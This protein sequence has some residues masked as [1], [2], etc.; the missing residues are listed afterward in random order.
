[1]PHL[2]LRLLRVFIRPDGCIAFS[3]REG[4]YE[5]ANESWWRDVLWDRR[6]ELP[7][8]RDIVRHGD[9][10]NY[11][12]D[13]HR[14]NELRFECACGQAGAVSTKAKLILEFGAETNVVWLCRELSGCRNRNKVSNMCRAT[15]I[16]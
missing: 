3:H 4:A 15:P 6:A 12:I 2:I 16:L 1:M 13:R 9:N 14:H 8:Q 11:R 10:A 5:P 7:V